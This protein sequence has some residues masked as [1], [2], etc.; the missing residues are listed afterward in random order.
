MDKT[1]LIAYIKDIEMALRNISEDADIPWGIQLDITEK[2]NELHAL[3]TKEKQKITSMRYWKTVDNSYIDGNKITAFTIQDVDKHCA[4]CAYIG[5][6]HWQLKIFET[7]A[8]AQ[9][10]LDKFML[11]F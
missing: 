7:K 4:V 8:E 1:T 5:D 2:L 11:D 3:I 6:K 10:W 9:E